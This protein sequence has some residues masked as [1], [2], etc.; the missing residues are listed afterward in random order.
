M[1]QRAGITR[2]KYIFNRNKFLTPD[3]FSNKFSLKSSNFPKYLALC[4][5]IPRDWIWILKDTH[6]TPAPVPD[7]D[8]TISINKLS[9][10]IVAQSLI[11]KTFQ[12]PTAERRMRL[13]NSHDNEIQI[14]YI[15][16]F[17][18][19]KDLKLAILQYKV[20]HHIVPTNATLFRNKIKE[21]PSL[22]TK[23]NTN[24]LI[25]ILSICRNLLDGIYKSVEY[26]KWWFHRAQRRKYY[27]WI[28]YQYRATTWSE[29]QFNN[30]KILHLH[31]LERR[32]P[33]FLWY[34]PCCSEKQTWHRKT[35]IKIT[36]HSLNI[37][38][39]RPTICIL[40]LSL[41]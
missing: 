29:P 37:I 7:T 4:N 14:I 19:T 13:S 2:V 9:C 20:V 39:L 38:E 18:V 6:E 11:A 5:A 25:C 22:G 30:C 33:L 32:R 41:L 21:M 16:P 23:T 17:N 1:A 8:N 12:P 28:H 15:I 40:N 3:V 24:P 26:K 27:L 35:Q 10:K 31:Y 36:N 34:L